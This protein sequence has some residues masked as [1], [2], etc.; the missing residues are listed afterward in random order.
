MEGRDQII[1][2]LTNKKRE[3]AERRERLMRPV[4]EVEKELDAVSTTLALVLRDEIP[5]VDNAFPLRKLRNLTQTQALIEI[6]RY[7][8]GSITS[9]EARPI[10]IAAKLM[11]NSKN[12]AHMVNGAITRSGLFQRTGRGRYRLVEPQSSDGV[13]PSTVPVEHV[14]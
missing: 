13:Q 4:Q 3:L 6:A 9:L 10:L 14:Q 2:Y 5:T 8:G 1:Q 11:K 12:A 7:N